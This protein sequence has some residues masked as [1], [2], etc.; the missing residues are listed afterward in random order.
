MAKREK[1]DEL[2]EQ[3]ERSHAMG[4]RQGVED[5]VKVFWKFFANDYTG[6]AAIR[7]LN[8]LLEEN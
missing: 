3:G 5:A 7:E 4:Y 1:R 6:V 2:E 8:K